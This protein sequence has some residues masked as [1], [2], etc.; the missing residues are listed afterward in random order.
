MS[1]IPEWKYKIRSLVEGSNTYGNSAPFWI[2]LGLIF[3]VSLTYPTM[4]NPFLIN[5]ST[6]YLALSFLGLS[7][8]LVWGYCGIL[9]FGQVAFFGIAGYSYAVI[10][11]NLT[12]SI[13]NMLATATSIVMTTVVALII[14]YFIFYGG[15]EDVYVSIITLVIVL[16]LETFMAQTAGSEWSVGAADLGGY[17][18]IPNV[19]DIKIGIHQTAIT[20]QGIK[21]YYLSLFLLA[22]TYILL[23]ILANSPF[24]MK[25]VA[26]R[27]AQERTKTFGFN[28]AFIKMI[29]FCIGGLLAAV[30]GVL[31][32]SWGNFIDPS[33]FGLAFAA[34]PVV[35][36]SIGGRNS[37]LGAIFATIVIER[38]SSQLAVTGSQWAIIF[39]GALLVI[40]IMLLPEGIAPY[41]NK[42]GKQVIKRLSILPIVSQ[43]TKK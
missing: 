18:G 29:T 9:S 14:G 34:L 15:V 22:S 3:V 38:I 13:G 26:V 1:T 17:N 5:N 39:I 23:R 11:I 32:T 10:A 2:V 12:S 43:W 36:V 37:L 7:L 27:E 41:A 40:V 24:G 42:A 28:V 33:V 16:V 19:P 8:C 30:G 21:L 25:M 31:W 6:Q 20:F 4:V 35:W